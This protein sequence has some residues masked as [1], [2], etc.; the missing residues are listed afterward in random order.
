MTPSQARNVVAIIQREPLFYRNFGVYWWH[1]KREL[2]RLG[3]DQEQLACLGDYHDP[4]VDEV[5]K[6]LSSAELDN[7]AFE[8]QYTA[9]TLHRNR[10]LH[11]SMVLG[12]Y[13]IRD[14]DAE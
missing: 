4:L 12:P 8:T 2:K 11:F 10:D 5:Y 13:V 3:Y 1:V 14:G 6:G 7:L 9:A